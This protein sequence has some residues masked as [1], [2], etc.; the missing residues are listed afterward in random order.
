LQE[1]GA[2]INLL[3]NDF[4]VLYIAAQCGYEHVVCCPVNHGT[5]SGFYPLYVAA[6]Y[7]H[8]HVVR[9]LL[10]E[11]GVDVNQVAEG[12]FTALCVAADEGHEHVVRCLLGDFGANVNQA[13]AHGAK[14]LYIAAQAEHEPAVRC[15]VK[16]FRADVNIAR[17]DGSTPLMVAAARKH[18]KHGADAQTLHHQHSIT[19]ADVSRHYSAPASRLHTWR[20]GRTAPNPDAAVRGSRSAGCLVIFYWGKECQVEHWLVHKAECKRIAGLVAG[21]KK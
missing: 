18:T 12:G 3:H 11:C 5:G 17:I 4:R 1:L 13:T 21:K 15:L 9:Y 10:G 2:N 8:E 6:Q 20:R 19:A 14:A 16:E 7:G